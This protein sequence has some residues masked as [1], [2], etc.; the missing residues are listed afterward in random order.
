MQQRFLHHYWGNELIHVC[1]V[2]Y[3]A[4]Q[5][6]ATVPSVAGWY[7]LYAFVG[8][9]SIL[10]V[11]AI[12]RQFRPSARLVES[13]RQKRKASDTTGGCSP[14]QYYHPKWKRKYV[15]VRDGVRVKAQFTSRVSEKQQVMLLAAPLGQCGPAIYQPIISHFGDR[16]QYIT[17]DYRGFFDS[18]PPQKP[19]GMAVPEHT[20]DALE[21][22]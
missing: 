18:E 6:N 4:Q 9:L 19:R 20:R 5:P 7:L 22:L 2:A 15:V 8:W 1:L 21:V 11:I 17:W 12:R 10:C 16:F 13:L 14:N 3:L